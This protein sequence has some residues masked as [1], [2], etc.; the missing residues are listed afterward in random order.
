MIK[1]KSKADCCGCSACAEICAHYAILL[2]SDEEGFEYPEIDSPKCVNCGLCEKVCPIINVRPEQV[3]LQKAYLLQIKD[4]TIR[5]ESTSGGSFTAIAG[6]VIKQ[7]GVVFG[8]AFDASLT[9]VR[10]QSADNEKDLSLFRNSKYVQSE[11]GEAYKEA[12]SYL[13]QDRW[14][15]FS[16]TPCQIE[17][18]VSFLAKPYPKL[19]LIDVVCYGIPSPGIFKNYL[20]W[21]KEKLGGEFIRFLFREKLLSYNYTSIS[22]YNK[23]SN[24]DY[25]CGV[26]R[27]KFMRSFFSGRN[28]RPSCYNCKF[29]KRYR[30]SDFT[31]WDCYEVEKFTK[32]MDDK[33]T[34]RVLAHTEKAVY[35]I[36]EIRDHVRLIE[37]GDIDYFIKDE[38]AM[39]RSV[40]MPQDR[41]LFFAD[42]QSIPFSKFID[43]WLKDTWA[44]RLNSFLRIT[45]YKLGIYN[46]AKKVV[47]TILHKN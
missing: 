11:I 26:E 40:R 5:K 7:G 10:H 19:L 23:E 33:G 42:Y 36:N 35:I 34:N 43:K 8:A 2:S 30:V 22:I 46:K 21:Q 27:D 37:Y 4:E 3:S 39:T 31:I 25:H 32:N 12:R 16:G 20:A 15:C 38:T 14:V 1:L 6:W 13:K 44:V 28:V 9:F 18:L 41:E 24:R 17:G 45:A 29:K 47:K